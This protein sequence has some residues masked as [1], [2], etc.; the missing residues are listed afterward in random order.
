MIKSP[1]LTTAEVAAFL[2]VTT[3]TLARWRVDG[4]GPIYSKL[5]GKVIYQ[6]PDLL[7]FLE[8]KKKK[9]TSENSLSS[10]LDSEQACSE[11]EL[12]E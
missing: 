2:K 4:C 7:C 9:S 1:C 5:N 12:E 8:E 3:Q 10:P 11:E 6:E